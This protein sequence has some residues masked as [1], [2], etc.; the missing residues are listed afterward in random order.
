MAIKVCYFVAVSG[1]GDPVVPFLASLFV[2]GEASRQPASRR[3][4]VST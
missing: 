4:P 2:V 3:G 1:F